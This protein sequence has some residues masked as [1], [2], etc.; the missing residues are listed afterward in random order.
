MNEHYDAKKSPTF[1]NVSQ[2]IYVRVMYTHN[3]SCSLK[4]K[5][6]LKEHLQKICEDNKAC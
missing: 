4:K 6:T 5:A 3:I 1:F 2:Y